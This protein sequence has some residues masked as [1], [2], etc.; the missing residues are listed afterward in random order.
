MPCLAAAEEEDKQEKKE[1]RRQEYTKRILIATGLL[2]L[3]YVP[4]KIRSKMLKLADVSSTKSLRHYFTK[5]QVQSIKSWRTS[6]DFSSL[7]SFGHFLDD[8]SDIRLINILDTAIRHNDH[9]I[10]NRAVE[11]IIEHDVRPRDNIIN[12]LDIAIHHNNHDIADRAIDLIVKHDVRPRFVGSYKWQELLETLAERGHFDTFNHLLKVIESDE[13]FYFSDLEPILEAA[14]KHGRFDTFD[15]LF[16]FTS[17]I[18]AK[19]PNIL[20][21]NTPVGIVEFAVERGI[22]LDVATYTTLLESTAEN[23]EIILANKLLS[24][25]DEGGIKLDAEI[26]GRVLEKL[27]E[28]EPDT[29]FDNLFRIFGGI[30]DHYDRHFGAGAYQRK[31]GDYYDNWQ[32]SNRHQPADDYVGN[33]YEALGIKENASSKEIKKAFRRLVKKFHPDKLDTN[34]SEKDKKAAVKEFIEVESAYRE[35][36][37]RGKVD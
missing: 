24:L 26:V 23:G 17:K 37:R 15:R 35:L 33:P 19:R 6:G 13:L 5:E 28:V 8:A 31:F 32:R 30:S 18:K 12:I 27:G 22:S 14:A 34:I 7:N 36:Q 3:F 21:K 9:N 2:I 4:S 29:G 1:N 11:L 20:T 25:A 10:A 16:K